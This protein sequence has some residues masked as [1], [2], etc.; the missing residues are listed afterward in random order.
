MDNV[1][2][3]LDTPRDPAPG[4]PRQGEAPPDFVPLRLVLQGGEMTISL[5]RPD[6]M[7]GRHSESD[8]RLPLPDVSRRHCR[9]VFT[10]SRWQV[11]DL[12]SLNGLHI[13]GERVQQATLADKDLVR[14]G[15][16]NFEVVLPGGP[17]LA[18]GTENATDLI[19][20]IAEALPLSIPDAAPQKRQAS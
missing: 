20:S 15:S 7:F 9:F 5:S 19:Q 14:I 2:R 6:M 11:F 3:P 8:V 1:S 10:E 13:N 18:R 4:S 12:N 16:F 17:T